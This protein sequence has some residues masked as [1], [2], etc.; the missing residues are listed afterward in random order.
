MNVYQLTSSKSLNYGLAGS[1][2]V[3]Q[4][5]PALSPTR[6]VNNFS[7][8]ELAGPERL[9]LSVQRNQGFRQHHA[10]ALTTLLHRCLLQGDYL[11]AGRTWGILLRM[12]ISSGSLNL[13]DPDHWGLGAEILYHQHSQ[14]NSN[15]ARQEGEPLVDRNDT[16]EDSPLT[17]FYWF[18]PEGFK[19]AREYFERLILQYPYQKHYDYLINAL[20]FY[21]AMFGLWIYS[22]QQQHELK[23]ISRRGPVPKIK[24]HSGEVCQSAETTSA[25]GLEMK[26]DL[27]SA[28]AHTVYVDRAREI[29]DQ[30]DV[31]LLSPPFSDD[32]RLCSLQSMV[33]QWVSHISYSNFK[34]L[35]MA[36]AKEE[37]GIGSTGSHWMDS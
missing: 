26:E 23:P 19:K 3:A 25:L 1:Q 31:L 30:L 16:N 32:A 21:P 37:D 24:R 17:P 12:R 11:R 18:N 13:R 10:V 29:Q 15:T 6:L 33:N 36:S 9:G 22:V 14:L 8:V 35:K 4:G 5:S 34:S 20:D 27:Q 28:E 2:D 7:D